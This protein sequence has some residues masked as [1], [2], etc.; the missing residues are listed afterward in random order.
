MLEIRAA[1][2]LRC[3]HDA[4]TCIGVRGLNEQYFVVPDTYT[5]V[6]ILS[7]NPL[8]PM[9]HFRYMNAVA[10]R[11]AA[12]RAAR[13]RWRRSSPGGGSSLYYKRF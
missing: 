5:W 12:L 11:R 1:S 13:P 7:L 6:G 2:N 10:S 8:V 9:F 4:A 3:A